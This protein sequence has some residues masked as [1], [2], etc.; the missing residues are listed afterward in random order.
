MSGFGALREKV[1]EKAATE[2][3]RMSQK[4]KSMSSIGGLFSNSGHALAAENSGSEG[5]EEEEEE[6]LSDEE[7]EFQPLKGDDLLNFKND[8]TK[9]WMDPAQKYWDH[10]GPS[11]NENEEVELT[12]KIVEAYGA[13][14]QLYKEIFN[15]DKGNESKVELRFKPQDKEEVENTFPKSLISVHPKI[16]TKKKEYG[17]RVYWSGKVTMLTKDEKKDKPLEK[18]CTIA[19]FTSIVLLNIDGAFHNLNLNQMKQILHERM[20]P[21]KLA[22]ICKNDKE[23]DDESF[24]AQSKPK[25]FNASKD[26][27][28]NGKVL[29]LDQNMDHI[30]L[31]EKDPEYYKQIY[32]EILFSGDNNILFANTVTVTLS[33]EKRKHELPCYFYVTENAIL[34]FSQIP[35]KKGERNISRRINLEE[36]ER[37]I[38]VSKEDN[39]KEII[40][41]KIPLE[42]DLQIEV[43]NESE[44]TKLLLHTLLK[45]ELF[46]GL[47]IQEESYETFNKQKDM[48]NLWNSEY[49]KKL[50]KKAGQDF[51]AI[52][53]ELK[54]SE[55]KTYEQLTRAMNDGNLLLQNRDKINDSEANSL[56]LAEAQK[57]A[58]ERLL[59]LRQVRL[60]DEQLEEAI[61]SRDLKTLFLLYPLKGYFPE[62]EKFFKPEKIGS[63]ALRLLNE[64]ILL[65][66]I[67][68]Q[69]ESC[70]S[71]IHENEI[72]ELMKK[73]RRWGLISQVE[74]LSEV[75][76]YSIQKKKVL[77]QVNIAVDRNNLN[78]LELAVKAA[79]ILGI[80]RN[81]LKKALTIKP[82]LQMQAEMN[83]EVGKLQ[84]LFHD[85]FKTKNITSS[86]TRN[87]VKEELIRDLSD[88]A[89]DTE[90]KTKNLIK[91][92]KAII[93]KKGNL[94]EDNPNYFKSASLDEDLKIAEEEI[95]L[96]K[97]MAAKYIEIE[98]QKW[99]D[100]K[101]KD[102]K[103]KEFEE[104]LKEARKLEDDSKISKLLKQIPDSILQNDNSNKLI[105]ALISDCKSIV[106]RKQKQR[107]LLFIVSLASISSRKNF[108]I[109]SPD[110]LEEIEDDMKNQDYKIEK[111]KKLTMSH[112]LKKTRAKNNIR[113]KIEDIENRRAAENRLQS[114]LLT[115]DPLLI[116][117]AIRHALNYPNLGEQVAFAEKVISSNDAKFNFIS[118]QLTDALRIG[119]ENYRMILPKLVKIGSKFSELSEKVSEAKII[120]RDE[121]SKR[122]REKE[123]EFL[124][125]GHYSDE[126]DEFLD[127]NQEYFEDWRF[128]EL[129][130]ELS[131]LRKNEKKHSSKR[132]DYSIVDL[133]KKLNKAISS[134]DKEKL[135]NI[136][137]E[138]EKY[139][140]DNLEFTAS[141]NDAKK[142]LTNMNEGFLKDLQYSLDSIIYEDESLTES[143]D[144]L[145]IISLISNGDSNEQKSLI[146]SNSSNSLSE[147]LM[148]QLSDYLNALPQNTKVLKKSE[149]QQIVRLL[150]NLL[151]HKILKENLWKLFLDHPSK[152]IQKEIE[153]VKKLENVLFEPITLCYNLIHY[154]LKK[155]TFITIIR[156]LIMSD[157]SDFYETD[158]IL[159]NVNHR[160]Y[161]YFTLGKLTKLE[162][163]NMD[164][165]YA[166][167]L[168]RLKNAIK[169]IIEQFQTSKKERN[170]IWSIGL[171][172]LIFNNLAFELESIFKF[173]FV[174]VNTLSKRSIW[175]M[176]QEVAAKRRKTSLDYGGII[177][178]SLMDDSTKKYQNPNDQFKYFIG[179]SLKFNSLSDVIQ[180]IFEQDTLSRFYKSFAIVQDEKALDKM[181]SYSSTLSKLDFS[182]IRYQITN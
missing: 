61:Q 65:M 36:I 131:K 67:R 170:D 10:L 48:V 54:F 17:S 181:M 44:I 59:E 122:I 46:D 177:L 119:D 147:I 84:K 163:K 153:N 42:H 156:E 140:I 86:M 146:G 64:E 6:E 40:I 180:C 124:I 66:K 27:I 132:S 108:D 11:K 9:D 74:E 22:L 159:R 120:L 179:L 175:D 68:K 72:N 35:L 178:P 138:S 91:M 173:G 111:D 105:E 51:N 30:E 97:N 58:F 45:D 135:S 34:Y 50:I 76:N 109:F 99:E 78:E 20:I 8:P 14:H 112:I 43:K 15:R 90:D 102:E 87:E 116:K 79:D 85:F 150:Y 28:K 19:L 12:Q 134:R 63:S 133:R 125:E 174:G 60:S 69:I 77:S 143:T 155:K 73:A 80:H 33:I 127:E 21:S 107:E 29:Y 49:D 96:T 154:T 1:A 62:N 139:E 182:T 94:L 53:I 149:I 169:Q 103:I 145:R 3:R 152:T 52:L 176:I 31:N 166:H 23:Q 89:F 126:L 104:G 114:S 115:L 141:L 144:A 5:E 7:I 168:L 118:S 47:E 148:K 37:I 57:K 161:L 93:T 56:K 24:H 13:V 165:S 121:E 106:R 18:E 16:I 82:L 136:I 110:Q 92:K 100:M 75:L 130:Q 25:E 81:Q 98:L 83:R 95:S 101:T 55:S 70:T 39:S 32:D 38:R 164:F 160:D 157:L 123:I 71:D 151:S 2:K 26:E 142:I 128:Q 171:S 172:N 113:N 137:K 158:S 162:V 117:S 41:F 129:K 167:P 88:L 4:R